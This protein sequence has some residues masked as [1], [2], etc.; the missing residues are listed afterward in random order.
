MATRRGVMLGGLALAGAACV[1]IGADNNAR[2]EAKLRIVEA[3]AGGQ[4]GVFALDTQTGLGLGHRQTERFGHCSS[5]KASLAAMVLQL[6]AD[7]TIS[8]DEHV[9]WT[10]DQLMAVSPFTTE[11][12]EQGATL[13][14]LAE[15]TQK[16]SDNAAANILLARLGGPQ[17]LTA[18]WRR[19]GDDASRLDRTEPELNNVP[20][21][22]LRDTTTPRA[23]ATT[24]ARMLYGGGLDAQAGERLKGWMH[25]TPTGLRRVRAGLPEG[26]HA[27]DKTGTSIWPGMGGLYVDIG[28]IEPQQRAPLTFAT[29]YRAPTIHGAMDPVSEAV[30]AQA[31]SIIARW[32]TG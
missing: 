6:D 24:L 10:R 12:L 30:L 9:R 5:F 3:G 20:P 28:F 14:E 15:A 27:G 11:R 4:L 2:L 16:Y 17:A 22:E 19:M 29:Y 26:W 32:A 31:G 25:D 8:A 18:F 7:G 13:H 1:P 21:G 23:M